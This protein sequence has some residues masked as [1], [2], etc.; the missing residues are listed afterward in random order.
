MH[1]GLDEGVG[2]GD[3]EG[4]QELVEHLVAGL[5]AL[6][7]GLAAAGPLGDVGAQLLQRLELRGLLGEVVVELGQLALLD[8]GQRDRDLGLLADPVATGQRRGER[9]RLLGA[10]TGEGLVEPLDHRRR[11]DLVG[12]A[13][14]R[15]DLLVVDRAAQVDG[16]EVALG[17]RTLDGDERAVPGAQLLELLGRSLLDG[18]LV[19]AVD[20]DGDPGEVGQRDLGTH[21]EL[22]REGELVVIGHRHAG[23][24]DL[25]LAQRRDLVLGQRLAVEL[26]EGLVDGLLDDR[27]AADAL[28]DELARHLAAAEARHVDLRTDRCERRLDAR[29]ELLGGDLDGH[30]DP[31]GG[32]GLDGTL[33][34]W[35]SSINR[36]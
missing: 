34:F 12:D 28:L 26:G 29:L 3:L 35:H 17:G 18:G 31:G 20:R 6:L 21:I 16:D 23:D 5:D 36:G 24:V 19:D 11:A 10:Q 25:G 27:P 30:L 8:R 9:R 4:L 13:L 14:D 33:H 15:V 2:H 32:Q 7:E 22:D 1:L